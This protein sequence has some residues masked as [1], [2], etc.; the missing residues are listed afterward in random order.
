VISNFLLIVFG[1]L[2]L[3]FLL[4]FGVGVKE[5]AAGVINKYFGN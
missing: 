2:C 4:A 5:W 3:A 1:V